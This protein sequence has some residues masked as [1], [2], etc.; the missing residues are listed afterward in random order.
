MMTMR[1]ATFRDRADA[2]RQLADRLRERHF[3]DPLVLAVP[4]GGLAVGAVLAAELWA[5][6]DVVLA[7]KLRHPEY[8]EAAMG[9]VAEGGW[10]LLDRRFQDSSGRS[11]PGV[12]EELRHQL[13]E[14]DRRRHLIR[15]VRAKAPIA[16]RSVI[17]ADDGIATGSTMMAALRAVRAER[18]HELIVAVPVAAPDRL[19]EIRKW[20]NEVVCVVCAH[21]FRAV[22]EFYKDF[23]SIEDDEV[24][25]LLREAKPPNVVAHDGSP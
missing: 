11:A 7:R 4:R 15:R 16:G 12:A 8:P 20:C 13:A 14:I 9:A 6:L 1:T 3:R 25:E 19:A 22:G 10:V 5:E 2:A 17:V 24:V 18:P 21:D 23:A